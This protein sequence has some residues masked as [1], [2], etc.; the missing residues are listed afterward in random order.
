[1][2][3]LGAPYWPIKKQTLASILILSTNLML[4]YSLLSQDNI[5]TNQVIL[6][7]QRHHSHHLPPPPNIYL[8]Y[9]NVFSSLNEPCQKLI[10]QQLINHLQNQGVGVRGWIVNK[11]NPWTITPRVLLV[12]STAYL[13]TWSCMTSWKGHIVIT[14][15]VTMTTSSTCYLPDLGLVTIATNSQELVPL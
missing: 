13:I 14:R 9:L 11:T 10:Y 12:P 6:L 8:L 4:L 15:L 7:L 3:R 1:M 5:K 2:R